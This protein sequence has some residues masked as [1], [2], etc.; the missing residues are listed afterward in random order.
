MSDQIKQIDHLIKNSGDVSEYKFDWLKNRGNNLNF[1]DNG[2]VMP[3]RGER[4]PS[5][6][7]HQSSASD[8]EEIRERLNKLKKV[9]A[10]KEKV[11]L[12]PNLVS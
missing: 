6:N 3:G 1:N 7:T 8:K 2:A 5:E 12:P 9:L 11:S 10:K 4:R